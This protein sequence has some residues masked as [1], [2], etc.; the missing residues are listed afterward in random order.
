MEFLA[1]SWSI[2]AAELSK[3]LTHT[4]VAVNNTSEKL[5]LG[6]V[7]GKPHLAIP[8]A[9]KESVIFRSFLD[10]P[11]AR[12]FVLQSS[13][14]QVKVSKEVQNWHPCD[15]QVLQKLEPLAGAESPPDSPRESDD[16]Q[17]YIPLF[18]AYMCMLFGHWFPSFGNDPNMLENQHNIF[19]GHAWLQIK[20]HYHSYLHKYRTQIQTHLSYK[21][22]IQQPISTLVS[23]VYPNLWPVKCEG[24]QTPLFVLFRSSN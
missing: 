4:C 15:L 7:G 11:S 8:T 12:N 10:F 13:K 3:A 22:E 17:V 5:P 19:S 23:E 21:G 20:V 2:S 14:V 24:S 6:S 18:I 16:T 9:R 1:R